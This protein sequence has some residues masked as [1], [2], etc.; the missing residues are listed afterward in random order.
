MDSENRCR[1]DF[2]K[3]IEPEI[4]HQI[5]YLEGYFDEH[6]GK[7]VKKRTLDSKQKAEVREKVIKENQSC[8]HTQDRECLSKLDI[9]KQQKE[10]AEST[11]QELHKNLGYIDFWDVGNVRDMSYMFAD[12]MTW[13]HPIE[14]VLKDNLSHWNVS[15]VESMRGMFYW[16]L[17][18]IKDN[19]KIEQW[20][21]SSLRDMSYIFFRTSFSENINDW[22][23][24]KVE[25]MEGAFMEALDFDQPL[26][27]W[28]MRNVKSI[29]YMF[30]GAVSFNQNL[31]AWDTSNI[32]DMSYTFGGFGGADVITIY[33]QPLESWDI[34]SVENMEGMFY[35][36]KNYEQS[37]DKWDVSKVKNMDR[38]FEGWLISAPKWYKKR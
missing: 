24:S 38:M 37:L 1:S 36:A 21:T 33:N 13:S 31:Q 34:S 15:K 32:V 5:K 16:S 20:D 26:D 22:N 18:Y 17:H 25:N 3:Y 2:Q 8:I 19:L 11:L 4:K 23:V 35:Y 6:F 27:K 30:H 28:D 12:Y 7:Y 14:W 9:F 29:S 10:I